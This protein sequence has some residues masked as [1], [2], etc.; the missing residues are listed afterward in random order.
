MFERYLGLPAGSTYASD[1]DG[2]F[3]L[4]LVLVGFWFLVSEGIFFWL[5]WKFRA[6][7]GQ[8]SQYVQRRPAVECLQAPANNDTARLREGRC[9]DSIRETAGFHRGFDLSSFVAAQSGVDL[10]VKPLASGFHQRFSRQPDF[11]CGHVCCVQP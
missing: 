6:K 11:R 1:I 4:I 5:L 8:P 9:H 3:T 7:D 10:L 2:L